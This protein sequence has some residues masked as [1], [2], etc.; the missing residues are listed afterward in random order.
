[1]TESRLYRVDF[2]NYY[3]SA[4]G[5]DLAG[6]SQPDTGTPT[7]LTLGLLSLITVITVIK[8]IKVIPNA[9]I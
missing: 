3:P 6:P 5:A 1:M 8:I 4:G 7:G 9:Q 2:G